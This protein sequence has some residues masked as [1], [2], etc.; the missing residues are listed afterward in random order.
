MWPFKAKPKTQAADPYADYVDVDQ[1]IT[2]QQLSPDEQDIV[3]RGLSAFAEHRLH[4]EIASNTLRAFSASALATYALDLARDA[5]K[6]TS[7]LPPAV[8]ALEKAHS[9]YPHPM[10]LS[11]LAELLDLSQ[12]PGDAEAVRRQAKTLE[13]HRTRKTTDEL[14]VSNL[15]FRL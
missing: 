9:I 1:F 3:R 4:P 10:L 5:E 7:L 14:L 15:T 13:S 2:T 12:R 11:H 8:S 6:D